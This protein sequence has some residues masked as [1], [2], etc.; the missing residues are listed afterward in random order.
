M[1]MAISC[2][3]WVSHNGENERTGSGGSTRPQLRNDHASFRD[4]TEIIIMKSTQKSRPQPP[5]DIRDHTRDRWTERVDRENPISIEEAWR[6]AIEVTNP[7][8]WASEARLYA[9]YG[10]LLTRTWDE[11]DTILHVDYDRLDISDLIH[12]DSCGL[13][14]DPWLGTRECHW[15]GAPLNGERADGRLTIRRTGGK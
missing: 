11:S 13:L 5:V 12:C 8:R 10:V 9:P 3:R 4:K 1:A 7:V 6:D 15:C 2:D 14:T